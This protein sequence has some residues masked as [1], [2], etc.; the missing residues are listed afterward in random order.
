MD[1]T[2]LQNYHAHVRGAA[3]FILL[4]QKNPPVDAQRVAQWYHLDEAIVQK[5]IDTIVE[6]E[7]HKLNGVFEVK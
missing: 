7:R 2:T 5:D 4:G 6:S 1:E 3:T